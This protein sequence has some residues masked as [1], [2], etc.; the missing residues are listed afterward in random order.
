MNA[1]GEQKLLV[2]EPLHYP[3]VATNPLE[4]EKWERT[5]K[6]IEALNRKK[7]EKC[8]VFDSLHIKKLP[9]ALEKQKLQNIVK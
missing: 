8:N 9:R 7:K 4:T 1:S 3:D 2:M 6:E 5:K